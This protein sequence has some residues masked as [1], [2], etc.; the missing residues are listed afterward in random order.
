MVKSTKKV[1]ANKVAIAK[2]TR[3]RKFTDVSLAYVELRF[4]MCVKSITS[5]NERRLD[6]QIKTASKRLTLSLRAKRMM[7]KENEK[8]LVVFAVVMRIIVSKKMEI[9]RNITIQTR[10]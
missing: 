5:M 8:L 1:D 6:R 4:I 9:P 10:G 7:R 3:A 2:R